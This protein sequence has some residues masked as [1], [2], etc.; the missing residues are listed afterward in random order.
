MSD[1]H[2]NAARVAESEPRGE[3]MNAMNSSPF[4]YDS[5]ALEEIFGFL[6][7]PSYFVIFRLLPS[8]PP[9]DGFAVANIEHQ[10]LAAFSR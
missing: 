10:K 9:T 2:G 5:E 3:G 7:Y 6:I 8:S 4:R 1:M